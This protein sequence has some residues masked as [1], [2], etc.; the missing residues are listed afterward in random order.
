ML[1]I[2]ALTPSPSGCT[3]TDTHHLLYPLLM[4]GSSHANASAAVAELPGG[5]T[6]PH[7]WLS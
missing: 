7:S 5:V 4:L 1:I 3:K 6:D 2:T